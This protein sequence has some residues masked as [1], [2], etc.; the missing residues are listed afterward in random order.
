MLIILTTPFQQMSKGNNRSFWVWDPRLVISKK[1]EKIHLFKCWK[2]KL[3]YATQL[4]TV[5]I[6]IT[7]IL[8]TH[9]HV[10]EKHTQPVIKQG[11]LSS[12]LAGFWRIS[13]YHRHKTFVSC[14]KR[15][16]YGLSWDKLL[17]FV[18]LC[19]FPSQKLMFRYECIFL[20]NEFHGGCLA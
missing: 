16:F 9:G 3:R 7:C 15:F 5:T 13:L 14:Y 11:R 17:M 8:L 18:Y 12:F 6:N 1:T 20:K 2:E 19:S 10:L 4:L